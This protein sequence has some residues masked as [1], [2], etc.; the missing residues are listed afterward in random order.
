MNNSVNT[1]GFGNVNDPL[2]RIQ[3]MFADMFAFFA[4]FFT[5]IIAIFKEFASRPGA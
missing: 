1:I 4:N 3:Q 5:S 2:P